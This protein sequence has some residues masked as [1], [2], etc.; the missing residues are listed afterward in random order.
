LLAKKESARNQEC[1]NASARATLFSYS[2]QETVISL[3][4]EEV[5]KTLE[6]KVTLSALQTR[7][8][9]AT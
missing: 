5:K 7:K 4:R 6:R 3:K 8:S 9:P 1:R 2:E